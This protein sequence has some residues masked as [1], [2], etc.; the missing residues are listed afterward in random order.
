MLNKSVSERSIFAILLLVIFVILGARYL[1]IDYQGKLVD[2]MEVLEESHNLFTPLGLFFKGIQKQKIFKNSGTFF[3]F[4]ISA[5]LEYIDKPA[6][7][8]ATET[9]NLSF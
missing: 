9:L 2:T 8:N 7:S 3:K 1:V 6:F 5:T 4:P